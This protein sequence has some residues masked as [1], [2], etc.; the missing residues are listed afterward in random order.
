MY[1]IDYIILFFSFSKLFVVGGD[2]PTHM[3]VPCINFLLANNMQLRFNRS[4]V[5]GNL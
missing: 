5:R 3:A 2:S 4:G 1:S